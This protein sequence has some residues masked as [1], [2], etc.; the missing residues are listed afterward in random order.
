MF[1]LGKFFNFS[2]SS[3]RLNRTFYCG[4]HASLRFCLLLSSLLLLAGVGPNPGPP[5]PTVKQLKDIMARLDTVLTEVR[6][7]RE[8]SMKLCNELS[9]R[10]DTTIAD[11]YTK[12]DANKALLE[13]FD[14]RLKR[15]EQTCD[16]F[17]DA[18]A[19]AD[20]ISPLSAAMTQASSS[21][22]PCLSNTG[23]SLAPPANVDSLLH[24]MAER[25]RKKTNVIIHGLANGIFVRD[26][27]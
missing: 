21:I 8:Q 23:R 14:G 17:S 7:S 9:A 25:D 22:H 5:V 16:A 4:G 18:A 12:V 24:E 27:I 2:H 13:A 10:L 19:T 11:I 1:P 3:S 15:V 6:E 26:E 20:P